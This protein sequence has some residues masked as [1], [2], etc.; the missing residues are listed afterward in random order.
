VFVNVI[1]F[2]PFEIS[3]RNFYGSK[4]RYGQKLGR[5]RKWLHCIPM[6]CGALTYLMFYVLFSSASYFSSPFS[7][8]L[9]LNFIS[10]HVIVYS[11]HKAVTE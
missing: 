3:S 10:C 9:L 5:V 4:T 6:Y 1:P 2:E 8:S 11:E 7:V